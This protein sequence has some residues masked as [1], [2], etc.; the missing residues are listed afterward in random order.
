MTF[1]HRFTWVRLL[2]LQVVFVC[3]FVAASAGTAPTATISITA[4]NAIPAL[5]IS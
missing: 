3:V 1:V 4:T 5:R 2:T